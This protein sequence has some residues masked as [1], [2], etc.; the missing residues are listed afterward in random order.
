MANI[1][2][3]YRDEDKEQRNG[4]AG[5]IGSNQD[6][7]T[8]V[9]DR[10]NYRNTDEK[11][12]RKYLNKLLADCSALV[13]LVGNTTNNGP[14][15]LHEINVALSRKMPIIPVRIPNT[16]GSLP[17]VLIDKNYEIIEW[18]KQIFDKELKK[19]FGRN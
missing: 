19:K 5:L 9:V 3:S 7:D 15:V 12:I 14:W 1:F 4:I 18:N 16:T 17:K 8:P 6:I 2:I 11:T 13:L 10:E